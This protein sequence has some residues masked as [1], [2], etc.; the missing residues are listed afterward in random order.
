MRCRAPC[1]SRVDHPTS[2]ILDRRRL[3]ALQLHNGAGL[4][5]FDESYPFDLPP[6]GQLFD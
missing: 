6:N 3:G 2:S 1:K 5:V 4:V